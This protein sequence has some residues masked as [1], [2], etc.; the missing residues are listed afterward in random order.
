MSLDY[1]AIVS[2]GAY[3]SHGSSGLNRASLGCSFGLLRWSDMS[4]SANG[5]GILE[6][7]KSGIRFLHSL[8]RIGL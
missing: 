7:G 4:G 5:F 6:I 1:M 2:R 3:P 8:F